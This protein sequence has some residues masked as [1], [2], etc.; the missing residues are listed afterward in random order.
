MNCKVISTQCGGTD[1]SVLWGTLSYQRLARSLDTSR[2]PPSAVRWHHLGFN[3]STDT[4]TLI[5]L[6]HATCF[7]LILLAPTGGHRLHPGARLS[8]LQSNTHTHD[9]CKVNW[10]VY[11][12]GVL[13]TVDLA[14]RVFLSAMMSK[15]TREGRKLAYMSANIKV[16][17][18]TRTLLHLKSLCYNSRHFK[19]VGCQHRSEI[20][21]LHVL[22]YA[23]L[24]GQPLNCV[25]LNI[26]WH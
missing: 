20:R 6:T 10:V 1:L 24:F 14:C 21:S 5:T 15:P 11:H 12:Q 8:A 2:P 4:D 16:Y 23:T 19:V 26:G 3:L 18:C 7:T 22:I 25:H 9:Y 13:W 17:C